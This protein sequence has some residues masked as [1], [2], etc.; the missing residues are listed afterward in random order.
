MLLILSQLCDLSGPAFSSVDG[1]A[2]LRHALLL[3]L[4]PGVNE[5][6]LLGFKSYICRFLAVWPGAKH[7]NSLSLIFIFH[8]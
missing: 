1:G 3:S 5:C 8:L 6:G 2:G 4:W 7:L